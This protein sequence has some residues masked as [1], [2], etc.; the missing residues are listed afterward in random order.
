[1]KIGI[2]IK[3]YA[4]G[5]Q[6]DK[7]GVPNKSG[8]EFHAENHAKILHEK[9]NQ[10]YIMTKKTYFFTKA[11][12]ILNGIDLVRLHA[13]FRWLEIMIRLATTHKNTDAFY[14]LGIPKFS[15]WV[16]LFAKLIKK[17][18]TL[19][20]TSKVEVFDVKKNWRNKI[21]GKCDNYIAISNE[22]AAG[23]NTFS[24]ISKDKIHILPQGVDTINRYYPV[25]NVEKA[26]LREKYNLGS[27]KQILLFCARVVPNKGVETLIKAWEIIHSKCPDMLL[28]VVGGGLNELLNNLRSVSKKMDNSIIVMG[29]VDRTEDFYQLSDMYILP[30][31]FEGL[32]T[33]V[34]EAMSCGLP[35]IGSKIGGIEDLIAPADAGYLP[36]S[37]DYNGFAQA[38][39]DI[40]NNKKLYEKFSSNAR[41]YAVNNLD[42]Y[43]LADNLYEILKMKG[44]SKNK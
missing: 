23:L 25:N 18:V 32:S 6:F 3:N 5:K 37:K 16:I 38:V 28:L 4:V 31:W 21:F 14:I 12:E 35:C 22:I 44:S 9:G 39:L 19:A 33:S 27:N 17:P 7:S 1:M 41:N 2:F 43:K 11:R 20:L 30:S 8:A 26:V 15:V 10:V 34:M 24:G 40:Q 36:E 29:E 13:P 42:C